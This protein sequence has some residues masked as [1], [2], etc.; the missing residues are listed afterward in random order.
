MTTHAPDAV[1]EVSHHAVLRYRERVD[2]LA[3]GPDIMGHARRAVPLTRHE[4]VVLTSKRRSVEGYSFRTDGRLLFVLSDGVLVTVIVH[5][6][7][8]LVAAQRI[9][10]AHHGMGRRQRRR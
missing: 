9:V 3:E 1:L 5:R 7:P 6:G 8:H 10:A 2:P 4:A